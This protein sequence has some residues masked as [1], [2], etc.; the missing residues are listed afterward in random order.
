MHIVQDI[1]ES[2]IAGLHIIKFF[3]L[4]IKLKA[5]KKRMLFLDSPNYHIQGRRAV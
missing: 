1:F 5:L 3:V 2:A 4:E